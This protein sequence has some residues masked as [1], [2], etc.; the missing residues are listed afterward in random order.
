MA[1]RSKPQQPAQN[2]RQIMALIEKGGGV[3]SAPRKGKGKISNFPLRMA[4]EVRA[5]IDRVRESRTVP[6]SVNDWILEAILDKLKAEEYE[7]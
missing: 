2:D 3:A 1:I 4:E 6:P 5:R 7:R